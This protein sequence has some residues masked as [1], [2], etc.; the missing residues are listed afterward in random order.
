M[1]DKNLI[2]A[3]RKLQTWKA[4]VMTGAKSDLVG[5]GLYTVSEASRLTGVPYASIRRWLFGYDF[6]SR[7]G[8]ER[9]MKPIW[10]GDL[11]A[12]DHIKALSFLDLMEVRMVHAFRDTHKVSWRAI[13][14]AAEEACREFDSRHPFTMKRFRTDGNRIFADIESRAEVKL[15]DLNRKSFV[16]GEIVNQSLFEGIEFEDGQ[17]ARWY[18][19]WGKNLIVIDPQRSFGRPIVAKEG[20]PTGILAKAAQVEGSEKTAASWHDVPQSAVHA[21]VAFEKRLAS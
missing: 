19:D 17:A 6:R 2:C 9:K 12:V 21:A 4:Q 13:R 16:M 10:K 1:I 20:V 3:L 18:P 14:Q 5:V 15:Y 11:G 7:S 8:S